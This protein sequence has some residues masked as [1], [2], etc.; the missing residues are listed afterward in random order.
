MSEKIKWPFVVLSRKKQ[1]F[2]NETKNISATWR[3]EFMN[4]GRM[5]LALK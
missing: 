5:L 4:G 1:N 2:K 3:Q